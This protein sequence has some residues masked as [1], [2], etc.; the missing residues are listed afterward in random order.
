MMLTSAIAFALPM[1]LSQPAT[2]RPLATPAEPAEWCWGDCD[3]DKDED[4]DDEVDVDIEIDIKICIEA[5]FDDDHNRATVGSCEVL[6]GRE[7]LARCTP[8]A[9]AASCALDLA[10]GMS[11]RALNSCADERLD[12]CREQCF[13]GGAGFCEVRGGGGGWFPGK[14]LGHCKHD[15]KP[16]NFGHTLD[17]SKKCKFDKGKDK[18][19]HKDDHKDDDHKDDDHDGDND[20]DFV[21]VDIDICIDLEAKVDI[22]G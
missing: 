11:T 10:D 9:V 4:G 7:C 21:F 8:E 1:A 19:D 12:T 5:K 16:D 17:D 13:S 14:G 15:H 20:N 22:E 2:A 3:S 18:D 6:T